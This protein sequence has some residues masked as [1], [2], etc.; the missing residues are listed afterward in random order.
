MTPRQHRAAE[1]LNAVPSLKRRTAG[2]FSMT[3][4]IWVVAIMGILAAIVITSVGQISD[5]SKVTVANE[6]LEMLNHA[7]ATYAQTGAEINFPSSSGYS[8]EVVVLH[9]LQGRNTTNPQV[10]SPFVSPYYRPQPSS[11]PADYRLQWNGSLFKLL[12]PGQTGTGLQVPFDGSDMGEA[13]IQP[14]DWQPYGR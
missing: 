8:D 1:P 2:G 9:Y 12:A 7:L 6:K 4:I 3:E 10:G 11:N 5:G 14:P 13:W